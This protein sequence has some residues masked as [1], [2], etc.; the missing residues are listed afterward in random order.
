MGSADA[1]VQEGIGLA[2]VGRHKEAVDLFARAVH[3]EPRNETAWLWLAELVETEEQRVECLEKVVEINPENTGA[4]ERL[5]ALKERATGV[6]LALS[7]IGSHQPEGGEIETLE[8]AREQSVRFCGKC[9]TDNRGDSRFC[10][11]CGARV[12]VRVALEVAAVGVA[13]GP[14]WGAEMKRCPYCAEEIQDE[15]VVCRYCGRDLTATGVQVTQSSV[16]TEAEKQ[17]SAGPKALAGIS[18]ACGA[19][20]LLVFGIPLGAIAL[21][22]GIPAL[23]MGAQGGKAGIILGIL[24]IILAIVVMLLFSG[25]LW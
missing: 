4:A 23:A 15:A 9:G 2:A 6:E 13:P 3:V 16:R 24:D 18:I 17:V 25:T 8:P 12:G 14:T 22:C 7:G 10:R 11:G 1:L 19:I 5:G 20:G 21:A